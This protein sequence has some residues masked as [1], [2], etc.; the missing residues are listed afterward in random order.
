MS[1]QII[2]TDKK[3]EFIAKGNFGAVYKIV[4]K[5]LPYAMKIFFSDVD[6][7]N[8]SFL[9][10]DNL[11]EL[12]CYS[13]LKSKP[14]IAQIVSIVQRPDQ[15]LRNILV[16]VYNS[17]GSP[18]M[19]NSNNVILIMT[20]YQG[21][22]RSY[23]TKVD[24]ITRLRLSSNI[25]K[26]MMTGLF[27]ISEK[28]II[29]SDL[30]CANILYNLENDDIT[31]PTLYIGDFG[32]ASQTICGV[33]KGSK[34]YIW[35]G[36]VNY[37]PPEFYL[38]E[39]FSSVRDIWALAITMLE[40]VTGDE[41]D[42]A[43]K[44]IK[45]SENM[46]RAREEEW[47]T[48]TRGIEHI[49]VSKILSTY[50]NKNNLALPYDYNIEPLI[51]I[52]N[53]MLIIDKNKRSNINDLTNYRLDNEKIRTIVPRRWATELNDKSL[54]LFH[55]IKAVVGLLNF[56]KRVAKPGM[57]GSE[58]YYISFINIIDMFDRYLWRHNAANTDNYDIHIKLFVC[59]IT[60]NTFTHNDINILEQITI[61]FDGRYNMDDYVAVQK[62]ILEKIGYVI[63]TCDTYE[64]VDAVAN[65][66]KYNNVSLSEVDMLIK[67]YQTW[68]DFPP[69]YSYNVIADKFISFIKKL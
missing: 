53:K 51:L 29:H 20:L 35:S 21:D 32:I 2:Y 50:M 42:I 23:T 54:T 60:Y 66:R 47:I 30:K 18:E 43:D 36:T 58:K 12:H 26:Q 67:F 40:F 55:Y 16:Q 33:D 31:K 38:R 61:A 9:S 56:S 8:G 41:V 14:N 5:N 46:I 11:T 3:Y 45:T 48:T 10:R 7:E 15:E 39:S 28:G 68:T 25:L 1:N 27:N 44:S 24:F 37:I 64:Y 4:Y 49:N 57:F 62:D 59:Y 63:H 17:L 19:I 6:E 13:T 69:R 34:P 52:L 22:L 65:A